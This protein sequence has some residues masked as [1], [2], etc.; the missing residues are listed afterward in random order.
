MKNINYLEIIKQAFWMTWKNKFLWIFGFLIFLGSIS[1]NTNLQGGRFGEE[2]KKM[3]VMTDFAQAHPDIFIALSVFSVIALIAFFLLKIIAT[4]AITKS[5]DNI[6]LYKQLSLWSIFLESKKFLRRLLFLELLVGLALG[7]IVAVMSVPIVYLFMLNPSTLAFIVLGIAI[8]ILIPLLI[9]AFYLRNYAYLYIILGDFKI[10]SAMESAYVLFA[11][12]IK[13][14]L[15]FGL[16]NIGMEF[17]FLLSLL[18]ALIVVVV[19]L[20]PLGFIAYFL[21]SNIGASTFLV[22][23]IVA[24]IAIVIALFSWYSAFLQTAWLLF[25]QQISFEKSREKKLTEKQEL[26]GKVPNPEVV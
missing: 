14:S 3:Q 20:A 13:E 16:L 18:L 2:S 19:V 1:P 15:L 11:K 26:E 5:A 17:L 21:F 4:V 8:I 6:A 24:L 9:L 22:I 7:L 12:N 23:G 25:F 10:K